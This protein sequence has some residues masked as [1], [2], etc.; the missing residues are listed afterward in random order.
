MKLLIVAATATEIEPTRILLNKGLQATLKNLEINFLITGVGM[1]ATCFSLTKNLLENKYDLVVNAGIAGAFN[2]HIKIG[3]TLNIVQDC[4]S[5]QGAEDGEDF[6]QLH[7][8][9]LQ[10]VDEFP[11]NKGLIKNDFVLPVNSINNWK[12]AKGITVNTVHGNDDTILKCVH[13]FNPDIESMEGASVFYVC[14][15]ENVPCLQIRTISNYVEKRNR[16]N[17]NIP[18]AIQ[19]LNESLINLMSELNM[20]YEN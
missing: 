8:L 15:N 11:F 20:L 9:N 13:Y 16:D 14:K 19:N 17:W 4:F 5:E 6:L 12:K 2:K 3:E 18:L 7:Q 10:G 1:I